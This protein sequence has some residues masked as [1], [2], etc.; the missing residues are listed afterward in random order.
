MR[1][2]KGYWGNWITEGWPLE[3]VT[4]SDGDR[5]I[6]RDLAKK[7][8]DYCERPREKELI[9]LWKDHNDLKDTR[10]LLLVDMENG[11]NEAVRF[12]RDIVCEGYMAQDWEMWLRKELFY[13]ERLKDDKPLTPVFYLPHR[14]INTE[15]GIGENKVEIDEGDGDNEKNHAYTWVPSM[16]ELTDEEFEEIDVEAEIQDPVVVV[17]EKATQAAYQLARE[18]FDGILEVRM[19]T[20]WFWSSHMALAYANFRGLDGMMYDFYDVPDKM[21]EIFQKL[22]DGYIKK[23]H[24]LEDHNLLY[25]NTDNTFVGSGGLGW[26]DSLHTDPDHVTL[27]TMWG[28]CEAQECGEISPAMFHEFIF[29]YHKQVAELFGLTCYAC[30]E[31]IDTKW[32]WIKELPNLRRVSVSQWSKMDKMSDYLQ[33][34]FIYSYKANSAHVTVPNMDE[35][36]IRSELRRMFE[37]TQ[38]NHV[39]VVLKDLHTISDKPE[40]VIR[41]VE[42]AREEMARVYG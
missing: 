42:I 22:T 28:L 36:L 19:R 30:C 18:V 14:A 20:W 39:E 26:T 35:D 24:F 41:W 2:D 33:K 4:I 7:F 32:E 12:D 8:R 31:G 5:K 1:I 38:C 15:W 40:Q 34:D 13:A 27:K 3:Q 6:L 23:L 9:R 37:K 25:C 17:D 10:P 11:W 21:K 29:P 16:K